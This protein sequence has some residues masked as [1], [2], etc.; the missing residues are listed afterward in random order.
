MSPSTRI[1]INSGSAWRL[2][3]G[4]VLTTSTDTCSPQ[5]A[6]EIVVREG[7]FKEFLLTSMNALELAGYEGA[8]VRAEARVRGVRTSAPSQ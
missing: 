7:A 1:T 3:L 6:H 5:L 8:W 4:E 2:S